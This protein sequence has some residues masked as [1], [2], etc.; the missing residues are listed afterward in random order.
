MDRSDVKELYFITPI[1]NVPSIMEI[2]GI[3][4]ANQTALDAIK[5]LRLGL[6]VCIKSD[7]F[8]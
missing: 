5:K 3:Y 7:I 4:V 1:V 8:F 6:T 2:L